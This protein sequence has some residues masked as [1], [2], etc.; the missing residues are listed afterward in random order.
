MCPL[1]GAESDWV[2]AVSY[3]S[4]VSDWPFR[5]VSFGTQWAEPRPTSKHVLKEVYI[6]GVIY[7]TAFW[8]GLGAFLT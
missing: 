6:W 1:G 4:N 2:L 3:V 8:L 7:N 5:H